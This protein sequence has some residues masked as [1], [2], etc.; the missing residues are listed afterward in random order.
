MRPQPAAEIITSEPADSLQSTQFIPPLAT[1]FTLQGIDEEVLGS[2]TS[3]TP[4]S[5]SSMHPSAEE[6]KTST[7]K[8]NQESYDAFKT[9]VETLCQ[10][11][12]PPRRSNKQF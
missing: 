3:P 10:I 2:P 11:M 8:Y 9:R 4:S 7:L 5:N 6:P 12:F 1:T